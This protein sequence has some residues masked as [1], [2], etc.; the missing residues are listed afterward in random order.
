[1]FN[2]E[3]VL[4]AV[5]LPYIPLLKAAVSAKPNSGIWQ[6][7][8]LTEESLDNIFSEKSILP[9]AALEMPLLGAHCP[10]KANSPTV[11]HKSN[12]T[13]PFFIACKANGK[14]GNRKRKTPLVFFTAT[15]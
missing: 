2:T 1:M 11:A 12:I 10:L 8:Q 3:G 9:N 15:G 5:N 7:A 14:L 4:R 6:L 13:T